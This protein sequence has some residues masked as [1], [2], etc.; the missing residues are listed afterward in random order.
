M[1]TLLSIL[2][3]M[4]FGVTAAA[5]LA[6]VVEGL[7]HEP[8]REFHGDA[9]AAFVGLIGGTTF[10]SVPIGAALGERLILWYTVGVLLMLMPAAGLIYWRFMRTL[11]RRS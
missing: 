1:L 10:L 4:V 9:F 7:A 2:V 6:F 8:E 11:W 5:L 3:G